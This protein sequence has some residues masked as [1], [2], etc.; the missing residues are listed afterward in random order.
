MNTNK[1]KVIQD[2][3]KLS[4]EIQEQIK[5]TYPNGFSQHLIQFTNKEGRFVSALPF[6]TDDKYYLVRM[7]L[8]EAR[9]IIYSDDDYDD[10]GI[11][12]NDV[13]EEFVDKY[14]ELDYMSDVI[15]IDD[16]DDFEE[17]Y[18]EPS[19]EEDDDED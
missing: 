19:D 5:L 1:P 13:K 9:E 14:A 2:F 17:K 11:L 10:D 7:T 12:K 3:E 6:E 15:G 8:D 16:E 4:K 18:D